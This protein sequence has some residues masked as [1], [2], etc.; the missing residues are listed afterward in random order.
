LNCDSYYPKNAEFGDQMVH[1]CLNNQKFVTKA[2]F[3]IGSSASI[4]NTLN[5]FCLL[6][7][8]FNDTAG[9]VLNLLKNHKE[10]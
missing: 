2:D 1:T 9:R 6:T 7:G 4:S 10:P 3:A 5:A 8:W